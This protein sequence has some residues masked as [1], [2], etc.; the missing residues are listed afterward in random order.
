M[1]EAA[2]A[3]LQEAIL[4]GQLAPGAPLRLE[5]LARSSA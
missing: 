5:E 4:A 2:V 3:D 1:A